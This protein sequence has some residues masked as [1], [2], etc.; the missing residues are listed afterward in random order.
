MRGGS[1]EETRNMEGRMR[2]RVNREEDREGEKTERQQIGTEITQF[3]PAAD[4][5]CAQY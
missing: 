1:A 3:R 4:S 5:I 2:T